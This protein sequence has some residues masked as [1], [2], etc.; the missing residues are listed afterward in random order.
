M[1]MEDIWLG[2]R[3][4]ERL[5]GHAPPVPEGLNPQTSVNHG[6]LCSAHSKCLPGKESEKH[7]ITESGCCTPKQAKNREITGDQYNPN[8]GLRQKRERKKEEWGAAWI[9]LAQGY[10]R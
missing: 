4:N 5:G 2:M 10:P 7:Q 1:T 3:I 9:N 6:N 8:S